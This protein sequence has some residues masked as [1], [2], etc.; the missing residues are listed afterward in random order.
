MAIEIKQRLDQ[1]HLKLGESFTLIMW[2]DK[3]G[4]MT[5]HV[6]ARVTEDGEP[7]LLINGDVCIKAFDEREPEVVEE[8]ADK[9]EQLDA[10]HNACWRD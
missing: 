5:A 8:N 3:H 7:Q 10:A 4:Q 6:E 1:A 2:L 9:G